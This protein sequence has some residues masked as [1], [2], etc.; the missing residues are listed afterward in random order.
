MIEMNLLHKHPEWI[1]AASSNRANHTYQ[2]EV[3]AVQSM[4]KYLLRAGFMVFLIEAT[5]SATVSVM[6]KAGCFR[7]R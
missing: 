7:L 6:R 3:M 1:S 5:T 4:L 2:Y